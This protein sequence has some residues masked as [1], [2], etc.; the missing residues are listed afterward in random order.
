MSKF[1]RQI[2]D[3]VH[4]TIPLSQ[5]MAYEIIGLGNRHIDVRAPLQPNINIHSSGFAGSIYSLAVLTAWSLCFAQIVELGVD[6]ELVVGRANIAYKKPVVA[7]IECHCELSDDAMAE[8]RQ[9]LQRGERARV[10]LQVNVNQ[11]SAILDVL[12]VALPLRA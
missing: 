5:H 1:A 6:A 11:G 12:L 9:L 4:T 7:A 10:N 8:Y 2:Q 3:K